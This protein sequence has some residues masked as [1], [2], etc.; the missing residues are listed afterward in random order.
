MVITV[1]M[2]TSSHLFIEYSVVESINYN[3]MCIILT[4]TSKTLRTRMNK[5]TPHSDKRCCT[6]GVDCGTG[7]STM[8]AMV[9]NTHVS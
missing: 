6:V 4:G 8:V 7:A 2:A 1:T 3:V 5:V 9:T